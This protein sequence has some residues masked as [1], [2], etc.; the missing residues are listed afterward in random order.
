MKSEDLEPKPKSFSFSKDERLRSRKVIQKM[1]SSRSSDFVYPYKYLC[2]YNQELTQNQI[3]V[4]VPKKIFKRSVDR[5]LITRR[6][7][8]AY[9][10]HKHILESQTKLS[11]IFIYVG[12][13]ILTFKEIEKK[14]SLTL[15]RINGNSHE[16]KA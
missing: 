8:E 13:E 1:F 11:I 15:Q 14:L 12:K 4:S 5:H 16:H 9:R 3:L 10:L 6:I 7:R 2:A